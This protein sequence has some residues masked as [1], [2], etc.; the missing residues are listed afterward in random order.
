MHKFI[1]EK[2]LLV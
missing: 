2:V 1:T